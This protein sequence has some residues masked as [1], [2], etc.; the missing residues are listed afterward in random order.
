MSEPVVYQIEIVNYEEEILD[1]IES[2][3]VPF[4]VGQK[5]YLSETKHGLN[6]KSLNKTLVVDE[7]THYINVDNYP[8]KVKSR[9]GVSVYV[10]EIE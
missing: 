4:T 7:I 6:A 2:F 1:T 10:H 8:N 5:I 9:Y 3:C